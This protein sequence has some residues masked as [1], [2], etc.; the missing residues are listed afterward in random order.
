MYGEAETTHGAPS[1][2]LPT[3]LAVTT[4]Q[5]TGYQPRKNVKTH[6]RQIGPE[7]A[8]TAGWKLACSGVKLTY[9]RQQGEP[10]R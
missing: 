1:E 2:V 10:T 6:L 7:E 8:P 9:V 3:V 5:D 4:V